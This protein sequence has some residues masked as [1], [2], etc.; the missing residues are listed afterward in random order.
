MSLSEDNVVLKVGKWDECS[1]SHSCDVLD[2]PYRRSGL[3]WGDWVHLDVRYLMTNSFDGDP[4][5]YE[6]LVI[7]VNRLW[8]RE[9]MGRGVSIVPMNE[10]WLPEDE[11]ED[12]D[13]TDQ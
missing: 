11:N 4:R 10:D 3:A 9:C 1:G 2:A 7:R 13:A 5:Q 8:A 12:D 6:G